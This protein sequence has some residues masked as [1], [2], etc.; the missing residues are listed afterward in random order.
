MKTV[1]SILNTVISH[2][3]S[4]HEPHMNVTWLSHDVRVWYRCL[5]CIITRDAGHIF[6]GSLALLSGLGD[7]DHYPRSHSLCCVTKLEG[8]LRIYAKQHTVFWLGYGVSK[9]IE[10]V[11][12]T[13]IYRMLWELCSLSCMLLTMPLLLATY[14]DVP[15]HWAKITWS[16]WSHL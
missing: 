10:L 6:W 15:S 13:L 14:K 5:L 3:F 7:G 11:F 1:T 16:V 4:S 8:S 12:C 2:Y 9:H